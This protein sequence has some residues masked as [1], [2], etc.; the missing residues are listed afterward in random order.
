MVSIEHKTQEFAAQYTCSSFILHIM[1][2]AFFKEI[3]GLGLSVCQFRKHEFERKLL[4]AQTRNSQSLFQPENPRRCTKQMRQK[5][6]LWKVL[7]RQERE[8]WQQLVLFR[9]GYITQHLKSFSFYNYL[10]M[11]CGSAKFCGFQFWRIIT[12]LLHQKVAL[13]D[14]YNSFILQLLAFDVCTTVT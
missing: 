13:N 10:E 12:A 11:Q 5:K 6:N 2:I 1:H 14:I 9:V 3:Y 4:I 7:T 8:K